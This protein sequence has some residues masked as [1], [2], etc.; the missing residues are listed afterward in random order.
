M[1]EYDSFVFTHI[2]KCGGSSLRR[3]ISES[4]LSSGISESQ[5]H[6]PG[7]GVLGH[8][9]NI[10]QLTLDE[11]TKAQTNKIK[12]LADHTKYDPELYKSLGMQNPFVFTIVRAPFER[13]ISH[14]NFFYKKVGHGKLKGKNIQDIRTQRLEQIVRQQANVQAAYMLN[15]PPGS[16]Q[17]SRIQG[18]LDELIATVT[19]SIHVIGTLDDT[20]SCLAQLRTFGPSWLHWSGELPQINTNSYKLEF[21]GIKRIRQLFIQYNQIDIRLFQ[22]MRSI[23][24]LKNQSL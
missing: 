8:D 1:E 15:C 18:R 13:F 21:L 17:T 11:L 20:N 5:I 12:I 3:L 6:I 23:K 22:L 7:E 2:P 24:N 10:G 4:A 9:K 16:E 14:Y 19:R